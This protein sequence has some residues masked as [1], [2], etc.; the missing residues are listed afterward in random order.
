MDPRGAQQNAARG[1]DLRYDL[2]LTLEEAFTGVEKEI[3]VNA[4]ATCGESCAG[5][6]SYSA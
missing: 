1:A 6:Q 5:A 2:E 4:L 3:T